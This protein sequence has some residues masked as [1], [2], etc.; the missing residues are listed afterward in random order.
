MH[1]ISSPI[2]SEIN[3][4]N[5]PG[6][7]DLAEKLSTLLV[8]PKILKTALSKLKNV[9]TLSSANMDSAGKSSTVHL[10]SANSVDSVSKYISDTDGSLEID[11]DTDTTVDDSTIVGEESVPA[12]D[13]ALNVR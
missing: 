13:S 9:P 1:P 7:D 12:V 4:V 8:N 10:S 2:A 6:T 11:S 3:V 5:G